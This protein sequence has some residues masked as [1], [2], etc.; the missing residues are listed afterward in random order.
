M[1]RYR[2]ILLA[3]AVGLLLIAICAYIAFTPRVKQGIVFGVAASGE[4]LKLDF[5]RPISGN[6]PFP[7]ILYIH[8][9]AWRMGG[10]TSFDSEMP[11][12][13]KHGWA[14]ASIDYRLAPKYKYPCQVDDVRLALAYL[15]A[16]ANRYNID[17]DRIG[18]VG[19]SSGG[20][21]ALLLAFAPD[22]RG[23]FAPGIRAV[24]TLAGPSDFR[25]WQIGAA[26]EASLRRTGIRGL[27][28]MISDYLGTADRRA[29]IMTEASPI[30][31]VHKGSPAVLTLQG[32]R[33]ELVPP[34]QARA[35][36]QALKNVG[37]AEKLVLYQGDGHDLSREHLNQAYAEM[38]DFLN[39]YVKKSD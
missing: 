17:P 1:K 13:A 35:L 2:L 39:R 18:V 33:D 38:L 10:R 23:A 8:G 21:L 32:D 3:A 14:C 36:H 27:D 7:L 12:L 31:Y 30:S 34:T 24:V 22:S 9:G 5:V 16:N 4:T 6:G 20:Q 11:W 15:R 25:T 29:A 28:G 26:E 19:S 37:A